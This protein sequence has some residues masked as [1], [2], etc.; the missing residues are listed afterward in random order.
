MYLQEVGELL[1]GHS[2]H[3]IDENKDNNRSTNLQQ[4]KY[5]EHQQ[6]HMQ[7]TERLKSVTSFITINNAKMQEL[8]QASKRGEYIGKR[9][10]RKLNKGNKTKKCVYCDSV[11]TLKERDRGDAKF[12]KTVCAQRNS[13]AF[14]DKSYK[15]L[16]VTLKCK[17]CESTFAPKTGNQFCCSPKCRKIETENKRLTDIVIK[18]CTRCKKGYESPRTSRKKFCSAEC[19]YG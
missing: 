12:C 17:V 9:Q 4:I 6:E 10:L 18:T 7:C 1:Q 3:H 13:K 11:F 8:A 16:A 2:I 14:S 5:S 15:P 19:R